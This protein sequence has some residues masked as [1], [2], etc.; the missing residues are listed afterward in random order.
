MR[1]FLL[2]VV[3]FSLFSSINAQTQTKDASKAEIENY[4]A[5]QASHLNN[6]DSVFL[7]NTQQLALPM[8]YKNGAK[9]LPSIVDH[10]TS[11]YLRPNF[12]QVALECG[13][14]G[15]IAY[16][17]T[18]EMNRIRN[19]SSS[20]LE[21]QY[22]THFAWN[23]KNGGAGSGVNCLETWDVLRMAGTPNALQWGG[24][25][26]FGGS[27]RWFSGYD[28]YYQA[29]KNRI[30]ETYAIPVNTV[31]GLQTL[32][33]WLYDHLEGS[34][35]GGI[36]NFYSTYVSNGASFITLP[37]GTPEGGMKV[38]TAFSSYVNHCQ[39]IIGFN[40]S[41]R[42][43]YN[44]DGVYTNNVDI[45]SDGIVDMR[46]WE[47]GGVKFTNSFG[48][49]FA[50]NGFCYMMYKVLAE[51]SANG[52]IWNNQVYVIRVKEEYNPLAAYKVSLTHTSR[53]KLNVLAGVSTNMAATAPEKTM[54]FSVFNY[55]GGDFY[56][57]GDTG[58]LAKTIEFGL[59]I[60]PLLNELVPG[61]P[62]KFFFQV[63]EN[64]ASNISN[65]QINSFTLMDYTS[66]ALVETPSTSSNVS[67]INNAL[68]T[69]DVV[70]TPN[71]Q[72][73]TITNLT[74][75]AAE[76]FEF[77][78]QQMTASN[79]TPPYHWRFKMGYEVAEQPATLPSVTQQQVTMSATRDGYATKTLPFEFPFY[80]KKYDKIV[81]N[82]GGYIEFRS[83]LYKWPFLVSE[84]LLFKSHE[85]IAP[86]KADLVMNSG[87]G[88]WFEST[89]NFVTVRWKMSVYGQAGT[90]VN[91][92]LKLFPNGDMEFYYGNINVSS[93]QTWRAGVSRGNAKDYL[94]PSISSSFVTNTLER[95]LFF[96]NYEVPTILSL[97]DDG[98]LSGTPTD[99]YTNVPI[100]IQV[101]DN[102]ELVNDKTLPFSTTFSNRV[103]LISHAEH[104]GGDNIVNNGELVNVD[105]EIKNIDTVPVTNAQIVASTTDPYISFID[106]TEYF[107]Y[108]GAGNTYNLAN[109]IKFQVS[110]NIP[111]EHPIHINI[112]T[113]CDGLP[114]STNIVIV[115]YSS[116]VDFTSAVVFDGNDHSL[117]SNETDTIA[118]TITNTGGST[119]TNLHG[120]LITHEPNIAFISNIDSITSLPALSTATL[121]YVVDLNSSFEDGRMNDFLLQITAENFNKTLS[122]SLFSGGV[123]E[124]FESNTFTEYPWS[125][126]DTAW[127]IRTD[128]A[129]EGTHVARSGM[130][131]HFQ[132]STM[133]LTEDV[134][135]PGTISFYKKVS[136]ENDGSNNWDYLA[137]FI[138]GQEK[139]RWDG[140]VDWSQSS[141]PVTAGNHTFKWMYNKDVSVNTGFD[142]AWVDYIRFPMFGS[143]NPNCLVAPDSIHKYL[144][145]TETSDFD[146]YLMNT[147]SGIATYQV[148]IRD[149]DGY[150]V[151]WLQ[152]L[153]N[154]G[155][156][157]SNE[158]D[159]I[160]VNV[161]PNNMIPG[162]YYA[163]INVSYSNGTQFAIPVQLTV[164]LDDGVIEQPMENR[165]NVYPN[166]AK[167]RVVFQVP[168]ELGKDAIISIYSFSGQLVEKISKSIDVN[169]EKEYIWQPNG[170]SA[171]V[172]FYE[173]NS[174]SYSLRGKIT[175]IP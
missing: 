95:K 144:Y 91:V 21:N 100:R 161:N 13:Q 14:A 143:S 173:L 45:N 121:R 90:Q 4:Y 59:D 3:V 160:P 7:F 39:T 9:S 46:D 77:Y 151:P 26:N 149:L 93:A 10:A 99:Y 84:D 120:M 111:N 64:D 142:A 27:K 5:S 80:G 146:L 135:I 108:I 49:A 63:V 162:E 159:S 153:Y 1:R 98:K 168:S 131:T 114:S 105:L 73:P 40:D 30:Y 83:N 18:Y 155:S 119:I 132:T 62:A 53:G 22:P 170:L 76:A 16:T 52:G 154:S 97:S 87:D 72:K 8:E 116:N 172:Y 106:N 69:M 164:L 65:G 133:S 54:D 157:N 51:T 71:H 136:C 156:V 47:I 92:A 37:A 126:S 11:Q 42:Y 50:D 94:I 56:M 117:N 19:L 44:G 25:L 55:Q 82:T 28:N 110:P 147:A 96:D 139:E 130:I 12:Y 169:E 107:G 166:P 163:N 109:A 36:A 140:E 66:G 102:N 138:D 148:Q 112:A 6:N 89:P 167:D 31:E 141:F 115:A 127:T 24:S 81:I 58:E 158:S 57:Q 123:V 124:D 33:Y 35:E 128:S 165:I 104:A 113:Q 78:E 118:V 174:D 17:F 2:I 101:V 145:P 23:F 15:G 152:P 134:L 137:F 79:G 86:F 74:L 43:D 34:P 129:F 61:T 88:I 125:L 60:S 41:I 68:T 20:D 67:I 103:V 122:F 29:M 48:T 38:I 32:K 85:L 171:G 175:L 150:N 70:A 75:P